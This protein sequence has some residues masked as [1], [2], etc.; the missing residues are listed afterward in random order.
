ME[1]SISKDIGLLQLANHLKE[2]DFK[3]FL[4]SA[5]QANTMGLLKEYLEIYS[6][7]VEEGADPGSA[8]HWALVDIIEIKDAKK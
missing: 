4:K 3:D 2:E 7:I 5:G 6:A 1:K 8:L